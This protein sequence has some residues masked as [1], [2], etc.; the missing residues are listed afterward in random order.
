MFTSLREPLDKKIVAERRATIEARSDPS[1]PFL[2]QDVHNRMNP[3]MSRAEQNMCI[4]VIEYERGASVATE[5]RINTNIRV[6]GQ[7][8]EDKLQKQTKRKTTRDCA[9]QNKTK[10]GSK[11]CWHL[12]LRDA[13]TLAQHNPLR[14]DEDKA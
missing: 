7:Q 3:A 11:T 6:Q 2:C 9:I 10:L 8:D 14:E 5:N 13:E 4:I 12:R 1:D